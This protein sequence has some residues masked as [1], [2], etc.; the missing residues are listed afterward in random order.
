MRDVF[1]IVEREG[2]E[3]SLWIRVGSAFENRDGS[4]TL[5]LDA[6]PVNGKL[7][8]RD[9]RPRE[10]EAATGGTALRS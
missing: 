3:K 10:G 1:A 5:L 6:L 7:Q 8:V 4:T 2:M 9:R